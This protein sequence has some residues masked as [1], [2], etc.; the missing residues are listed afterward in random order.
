ME[1]G[2]IRSRL[3]ATTYERRISMNPDDASIHGSSA[4][5][6]HFRTCSPCSGN[7][8][9]YTR[10][11]RK[12]VTCWNDRE[13]DCIKHARGDSYVI[14]SATATAAKLEVCT[15]PAVQLTKLL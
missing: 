2:D 1:I 11:I 4:D 9:H 8:N 3:A 6:V 10:W 5:C 13:T 12:Q 7:Q 15:A 14:L